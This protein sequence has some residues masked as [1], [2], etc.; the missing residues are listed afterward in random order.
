MPEVRLQE[1]ETRE[2]T[3]DPADPLRGRTLDDPAHRAVAARLGRRLRI[4]ETRHGLGISADQSVGVVQLGDL[5]IRV[6]PKLA[7]ADMWHILVYALGFDDVMQP[8][9][10]ELPLADCDIADLLAVLLLREAERLRRRGLRRRYVDRRSW[11]AQP[12]GRVNVTALAYAPPRETLPCTWAESTTDTPE[13]QVVR[14]GLALARSGV[15]TPVIGSRLGRADAVWTDTASRQPLTSAL[16]E[17]VERERTRLTAMYEPAHRLVRWI[18]EGRAVDPELAAGDDELPGVLWDMA[19]LFELFVARFLAE[20]LTTLQV[21]VQADLPHLYR[22]IHDPRGGRVPRPR[23]DV[24]VKDAS[25]V[26]GVLDTKYR[27]LW[28]TPLPREIL[29]QMSVYALAWSNASVPVPGT[30]LYPQ[31]GGPRPDV[32]LALTPAQAPPTRIVLRAIDWAKAARLVHDR[33]GGEAAELAARWA[34][35]AR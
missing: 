26:V 8:D 9:S 13:N 1:W 10:T 12:R 22:R 3:R 6:R 35:P 14:A 34:G 31:V 16:L 27:D 7:V 28:N 25:Q 19:R 18:W 24:V 17:R 32:V 30:V 11:L 2:A 20:H 4:Y 15:R 29:Y 21:T 33:R 5:A 23:P